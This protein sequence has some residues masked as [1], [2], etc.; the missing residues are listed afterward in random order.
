MPS[1][2][3]L[4]LSERCACALCAVGVCPCVCLGVLNA[5]RLILAC[6]VLCM[7]SFSSHAS[8]R[9]TCFLAALPPDEA[10]GSHGRTARPCSAASARMHASLC[11]GVTCRRG[12]MDDGE[13]YNRARVVSSSMRMYVLRVSS[14]PLTILEYVREA[15]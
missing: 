8:V 1:Y 14:M 5:F 11:T 9:T 10:D 7:L 13:T 12:D 3:P 2:L 6:Q 4:A 15:R